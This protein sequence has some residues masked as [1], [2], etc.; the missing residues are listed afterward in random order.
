M[1]RS[2]N[3]LVRVGLIIGILVML[4]LSLKNYLSAMETLKKADLVAIEE[5][6]ASNKYIQK[7]KSL[8]DH[9]AIQKVEEDWDRE[10]QL[11]DN[12][13][14]NFDEHACGLKETCD[15]NSEYTFRVISGAASVIG[16]RVC[17]E[18]ADIMRSKLNN[19]DRGMNVVV[20]NLETKNHRYATF[21]L[22]AKDSTELKEFL[23]QMVNGEI[24]II[25][26]YDDAAFRLDSEARTTLSSFGSTVASSIA[27]RDAWVFL[28]A[29]GV[30]GFTAK[31]NHLKNDK[32]AN[33]YG[34]WPEAIE[35][36]GCLPFPKS[37]V[38]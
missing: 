16:P 31:E 25:A 2:K 32:S 27:F 12:S 6:D 36:S 30:P 19:V 21:D 3:S 9:E 10:M 28:G 1:A 26:S 13:N 4:A 11:M 17:W 29:K 14:L 35:I 33:K 22:Y 15:G 20:I 5:A 38:V 24:I 8:I 7:Q 34:D 23:S 37:I 18:G